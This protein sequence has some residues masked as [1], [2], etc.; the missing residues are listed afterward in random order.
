MPGS[1]ACVLVLVRPGRVG[2]AGLPGAFCCASLFPLAAL[3]FCF[4]QPPPGWGCLFFGSLVA[5]PSAPPPPFFFFLLVFHF[6]RASLVS[7]FLWLPAPGAFGL[8]ALFFFPP[9]PR[10]L[11]FSFS[12]FFYSVLRPRCLWLSL[13]SGP[14]CPGPWRC[15]LFVLF[16]SRSSALCALSPL[17]WFP[18]GR[19]LLPGACCPPSPPLWFSRFSSL[20]LCA[21][22]FFLSSWLCAPVVSGFLWF[23]A[24]G[25]LGLGAV[26]C[27]FCWPPASRLSVPSR[28]FC[29]SRLAVGC[30]LV[31]AAPPPPRCVSRFSSLLLGAS[32]FF[33]F[34]FSLCAPIVSGFLWFPA[35][36]ALGFGAVCCLFC[37]PPASRL[38]VRSRLFVFPAWPLPAPWWLPPPPFVSRVFRRCC[39]VLCLFFLFFSARRRFSPPAP[40]PPPV[41]A[42]CLVLPGVAALR[43]P[44]VLRAVLWCLALL[45]CGL[46]R[47]VRC[48]LGCLFVCCAVL[49]VAAACCALSL[50]VP[51]SW[52]VRGV[53]CCLV[54]VC[55]AMCRAVLCAPGCGAAPRCCA[56][57]PPVLC[58]CVLC[59][60]V[61]LVWC[62]CLLCRVLWRCPSPWGPVL[63][64]AVFCA[65]IPRCVVCAVCVLSWRA[66]ACSCSP[67]CC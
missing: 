38:S 7:F 25:A 8:G 6:P 58:C 46:L 2:R 34:S 42:W 12:P 36:G 50:V 48:L 39:S 19:W 40:P 3:F 29:V 64:G 51:S 41:R 55:V 62:R 1:R 63:C 14:G 59:C 28:L 54:L 65:V 24:P 11:C 4:A 10:G 30:S 56:S 18:P 60:F 52:V 47:A 9:P 5:F 66:G 21:P 61:A 20:P 32:F 33:V 17:F 22:F 57:C 23:P 27:L 43:C 45:C 35:P 67:L 37:C 53:A 44:S 31:V 15:V 16:A 26:C 49:L 13:V